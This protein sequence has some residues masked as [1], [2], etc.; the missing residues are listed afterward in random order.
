MAALHSWCESNTVKSPY[1]ASA[2]LAR[3]LECTSCCIRGEALLPSRL[4][5]QPPAQPSCSH[6]SVSADLRRHGHICKRRGVPVNVCYLNV[7]FPIYLK[8]QAS[9]TFTSL[10]ANLHKHPMCHI[11]CL[12]CAAESKILAGFELSDD[13][14]TAVSAGYADAANES[15]LQHAFHKHVDCR[16]T[17]MNN[18]HAAF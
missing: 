5:P 17:E 9:A 7:T 1:G 12:G 10:A 13:G 15:H 16:C 11:S 2:K 6:T 8:D 4:L 3:L 14:K 18:L